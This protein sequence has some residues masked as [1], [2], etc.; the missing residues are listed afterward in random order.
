MKSVKN[1]IPSNSYKVIMIL[2]GHG[3]SN[4]KVINL[5]NGCYFLTEENTSLSSEKFNEDLKRFC[6]SAGDYTKDLIKT[7]CT[8]EHYLHPLKGSQ[9]FTSKT[10]QNILKEDPIEGY[11]GVYSIVNNFKIDLK[12]CVLKFI[13]TDFNTVTKSRLVQMRIEGTEEKYIALSEIEKFVVPWFTKETDVFEQSEN[14]ME[15]CGFINDLS[16]EIPVVYVWGACRESL[17]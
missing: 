13:Y 8:T 16:E 6:D 10:I 17:D 15:S 7:S 14:Q 1:L 2:D 4:S 9:K 5:K 3:L 12:Q 11:K